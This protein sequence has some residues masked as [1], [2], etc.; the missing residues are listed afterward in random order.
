MVKQKIDEFQNLQ[1]VFR[2]ADGSRID[3]SEKDLEVLTNNLLCN[4]LVCA[5]TVYLLIVKVH[6]FNTVFLLHSVLLYVEDW[7]RPF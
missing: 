7:F 3:R 1:C 2:T 4:N 6:L 5:I